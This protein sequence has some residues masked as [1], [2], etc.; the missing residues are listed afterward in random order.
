MWKTLIGIVEYAYVC[1]CMVVVLW[2]QMAELWSVWLIDRNRILING[3]HIYDSDIC[4]FLFVNHSV[5]GQREL[6]FELC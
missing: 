1:L 5:W 2:H 6:T 4:V 3:K